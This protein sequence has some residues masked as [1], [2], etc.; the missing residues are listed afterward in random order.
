[1]RLLPDE[2]KEK[3]ELC[4][5]DHG[6]FESLI[7]AAVVDVTSRL[8]FLEMSCELFGEDPTVPG[9]TYMKR[10]AEIVDSSSGLF[11]HFEHENAMEQGATYFKEKGVMPFR[12]ES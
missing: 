6:S 4:N 8:Q 11:E 2:H 9:S 7:V 3:L 10:L 12:E 1:M 5:A